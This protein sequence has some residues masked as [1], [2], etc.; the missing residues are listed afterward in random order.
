M[1]SVSCVDSQCDGYLNHGDPKSAEKTR[2]KLHYKGFWIPIILAGAI[3][4]LS[5][6]TG[7]ARTA[8]PE[9]ALGAPMGEG[10]LETPAAQA[11]GDPEN[12]ETGAEVETIELPTIPAT[13]ESAQPEAIATAGEIVS[14]PA[15]T[16]EPAPLPP[17][18]TLEATDPA[19]VQLASG[20]VQ[21][22]EFFAFW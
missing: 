1:V 22:V 5:G 18:D 8:V 2:M 9:A 6:C 10:G 17:R 13:P 12:L 15:I 16:Q 21:L 19:T 7:S 20:K 4:V 3:L 14:E 11:T